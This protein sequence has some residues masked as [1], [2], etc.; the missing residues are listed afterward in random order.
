MRKSK[1]VG[2]VFGWKTYVLLISALI[3]LI[4]A[5]IAY[6]QSWNGYAN[7]PGGQYQY[8]PYGQDSGQNVGQTYAPSGDNV[9]QTDAQQYLPSDWPQTID[10]QG[11]DMT[12]LISGDNN[13]SY[14]I[15]VMSQN[16][17][18][19]NFQVQAFC[20]YNSQSQY[21][22]LHTLKAP[23]SGVIDRQK[24]TLQ[25]DFSQLPQAIDSIKVIDAG[26]VDKVLLQS[27]DLM[28]L[29]TVM[30]VDS[31]DGSAVKFSISDMSLLQPDGV[32]NDLAIPGPVQGVYDTGDS[33]FSTF[34]Y[35]E[36]A[37]LF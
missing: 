30:S 8:A 9:I 22:I 15:K 29:N 25:I 33:R 35:P 17:N 18:T 1:N 7:T 3:L 26:D 21:A 28:V 10:V 13:V 24:N 20:V 12:G 11:L 32:L 31:S 27:K 6:G 5:G 16:D 37:N 4:C 36:L 19:I 14:A 34:A 2:L 23:L